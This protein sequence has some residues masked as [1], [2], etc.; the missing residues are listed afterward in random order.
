[1]RRSRLSA[2]GD[3]WY[4]QT[5][6]ALTTA[7]PNLKLGWIMIYSDKLIRSFNQSLNWIALKYNINS[8][9]DWLNHKINLKSNE[10]RLN[11]SSGENGEN[12]ENGEKICLICFPAN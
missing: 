7:D 12:Y 3:R 8:S 9:I 10:P 2:H 1:M 11:C 6:R 4:L 5:L